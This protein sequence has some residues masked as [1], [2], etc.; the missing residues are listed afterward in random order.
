[1]LKLNVEVIPEKYD[2]VHEEFIDAKVVTLQLEHSLASLSKWESK[3]CKPFLS[4]EKKTVEESRDYVRCMTITQNVNPDVYL[5]L[6][7]K[8]FSD[9]TAY[10]DSPMTAT[11]FSF[12][13]KKTS[14][15]IF[16]AE[17]LYY[18][19]MS[20]NIPLECQKWHLNKLITLIRVF[21]NKNSKPTKATKA[22]M[23]NKYAAMN[24]ARRAKNNSK[25]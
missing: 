12:D 11:T 19:M 6:T 8:N 20:Y 14:G 25:G 16:T 13:N 3:W 5:H 7:N 2:S 18:I 23:A 10:I 17:L 9:I 24:A 4:K 22:E 15:Q 1:M 21:E